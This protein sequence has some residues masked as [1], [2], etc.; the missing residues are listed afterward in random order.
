M[1]AITKSVSTQAACVKC[2]LQWIPGHVNIPGNENTDKTSKTKNNVLDQCNEWTDTANKVELALYYESLSPECQRF[3]TGTL[4]PNF[5]K[6]RS[7][8]NL[9]LVPYG[10]TR[11]RQVHDQYFFTCE[12]GEEECIGNLIQ[13]CTIALVG[14]VNKYFPFIN[15]MEASELKPADAAE[16]CAIKFPVPLENIT[17]CSK[18]YIGNGL[19]HKMAKKTR[20]LKPPLSYVPWITVNGVHTEDIEKEAESDLVKLICDAYKG[21]KPQVCDEK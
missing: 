21:P 2:T 3:I 9:T 5:A 18:S 4:Y 11:E 12:H 13:T 10:K 16:K 17:D 19:E 15:C 20:A 6:L 1:K 14:D 7:I 8:M